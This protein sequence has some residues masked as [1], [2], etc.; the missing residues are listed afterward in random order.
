MDIKWQSMSIYGDFVTSLSAYYSCADITTSSRHS[1]CVQ[2]LMSCQW[3][4]PDH[5]YLTWTYLLYPVTLLLLKTRAI[6]YD[7][8]PCRLHPLFVIWDKVY[9]RKKCVSRDDRFDRGRSCSNLEV[10]GWFVFVLA[11]DCFQISGRWY[12]GSSAC[13]EIMTGL[14]AASS[15]DDYMPA[16]LSGL[17]DR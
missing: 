4:H 11:E 1:S 2:S 5:N 17:N 10:K 3:Y 12:F 8:T 6:S 15:D 14:Y 16:S 7:W 9:A 13:E